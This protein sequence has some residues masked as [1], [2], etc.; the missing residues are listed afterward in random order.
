MHF[1]ITPTIK[2]RVK[3][4]EL[5]NVSKVPATF[6]FDLNENEELFMVDIVSG[7][8]QPK[9]SI[10]VTVTFNGKIEGLHYKRLVVLIYK[11]VSFIKLTEMYYIQVK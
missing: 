6:Q 10:Y 8:I 3:A 1:A 2:K 9:K 11:H 7:Q 4:F 5:K